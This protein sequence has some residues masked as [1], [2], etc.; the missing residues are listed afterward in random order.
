MIHTGKHGAKVGA[1]MAL[2]L[3]GCGTTV[4]ISGSNGTGT[5][6]PGRAGSTSAGQAAASAMAGSG[7]GND[8][9]APGGGP[10]QP[11]TAGSPVGNGQFGG[12][13]A[14][15]GAS[16][17]V[18]GVTPTTITVGIPYTVNGAAG[19]QAIGAA[20]VSF[21]DARDLSKIVI[22]D[23]NKH[24]GILGRKVMPIY[25][26]VDAE[27]TE[28]DD[29]QL[30]AACSFFTQDHHVFAVIGIP[31]YDSFNE[32]IEK[33]GAVHV[34]EDVTISNAQTFQRFPHYVE[35]STLNLDRSAAL[36]LQ[37]LVA[38]RYFTG[39]DDTAGGP[40]AAPAKVGI[41]TY[42]H[43]DFAHPIDKV[44][45][46]ALAR[47]GYPS[48]VIARIAYPQRFS[49]LS[50]ETAQVQNAVLQ[51]RTAGVT[52]VI[53]FDASGT[54]SLFFL[55]SAESQHYRPRY[56]INTQSAFGVLASTG[57]DPKAQFNGAIGIGW[58]PI[59]DVPDQA[60]SDNGPYSNNARKHCMAL[61]RA[62]GQSFSDPNAERDALLMCNQLY[63][64][65][66]A[67]V[68]GGATISATSFLNGLDRLGG[69]FASATSAATY[70]GPNQHDGVAAIYYWGYNS[71]CGCMRYNGGP[72]NVG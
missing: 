6:G 70:L 10:G 27:S 8:L 68:G 32:C 59:I 54:L 24:G 53:I 1:A 30:A 71:A 55:Q 13:A 63:L 50:N 16:G 49:D 23:I 45:L 11:A 17:P 33:A 20:G 7:S 28:T 25:Y 9:S 42:D 57:D 29:Q 18:P 21:G 61:M 15:E 47:A 51:F 39:W 38:Q 56:G 34:A 60:A 35:P 64:L 46:P 14:A 66:Q 62:G 37:A 44:M 2:L 22:A 31:G 41:L 40:G 52:H 36:Q 67:V 3:T 43:P 72:R 5:G 12:A 58:Y 26:G 4:S 69:Q 19:N 48:P 65:R